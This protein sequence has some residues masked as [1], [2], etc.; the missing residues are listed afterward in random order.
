MMYSLRFCA[1]VA[2][3]CACGTGRAACAAGIFPVTHFGAKGDGSTDDYAAVLK[4]AAAVTAAGG[5]TLLFPMIPKQAEL[6][7]GR[8]SP[9]PPT[10]CPGKP[11][12]TFC[13]S[14]SSSGQCSDPMPHAP[15]PPCFNPIAGMKTGYVT[16]AFNISSN[17][18]VE[19]ATGVHLLG[20][21][22][23]SQ[24]PLLTVAKVWPGFGY[25][26]DGD[27]GG[28]SGRLMH[29][30]LIFTWSTTNVSVG[31]GGTI[32]CRG[33]Y[34]Q[35]CGGNLTKAPCSGHARPQCVFF[36]NATDVVFEDVTVLNSPDWT[37][38]FSSVDRLRV[39]RVN[40]TQ[41]GTVSI[42]TTTSPGATHLQEQVC[43]AVPTV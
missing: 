11:G 27:F 36:S 21:H 3:V 10:P 13:S 5:G 37:L 42:R 40:V 43:A 12:V 25:A 18:H 8:R 35:A 38:H 9:C 1:C 28:E 22:N 24:W 39:R 20:A 31:G 2:A 26:R 14:N 29:Q 33:S 17:T 34:F 7:A 23:N 19:I 41:P 16:G 4:A 15:C 32:D 30:S 6:M